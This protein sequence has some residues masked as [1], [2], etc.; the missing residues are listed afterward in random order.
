MRKLGCLFVFLAFVAAGCSSEKSSGRSRGNPLAPSVVTPVKTVT[1]A[2][3]KVAANTYQ[4]VVSGPDLPNSFVPIESGT[5]SGAL[6]WLHEG[7]RNRLYVT[8]VPFELGKRDHFTFP[9]VNSNGRVDFSIRL[10]PYG[11]LTRIPVKLN[12]NVRLPPGYK[13]VWDE[14]AA[15]TRVQGPLPS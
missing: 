14:K 1:I 10:Q 8:D 7:E 5:W 6:L 15:E 3:T 11:Q 4:V 2:I 12:D 9:Y 13:V